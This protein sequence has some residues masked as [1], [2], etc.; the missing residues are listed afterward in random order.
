MRSVAI[1]LCAFTLAAGSAAARD[2]DPEQPASVSVESRPSG[3]VANFNN[4]TEAQAACTGAGGGFGL[5]G[6][7]FVCVNP[8]RRLQSTRTANPTSPAAPT[9]TPSSSLSDEAAPGTEVERL[10]LQPGA[11]ASFTLAQG[12]NHQLLRRA[13]PSAA[14]AITIRYEVVDGVSRIIATSSTGHPLSFSVLADPDGNGGFSAMGE[15]SLPGDGT[16]ATR[17]WPGSLGTINVGNFVARP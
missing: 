4:P 10:T 6:R 1:A 9:P 12:F 2:S 8:R 11:R 14:G 17:S 7:R 15:I 16:P 13:S 5:R 3:T